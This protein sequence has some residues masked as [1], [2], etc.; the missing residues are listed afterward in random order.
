MPQSYGGVVLQVGSEGR[1][2]GTIQYQLNAI[3]AHYPAIPLLKVD[4]VFGIDTRNAVSIFQEIFHLPQTGAVDLA[5]WY[6]ISDLYVGV[7]KIA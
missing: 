6:S 7:S 4:S 3:A 1:D 2:V 5:T